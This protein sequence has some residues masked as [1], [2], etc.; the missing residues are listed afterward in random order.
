MLPLRT[1]LY[2]TDFSD[3]SRYAFRL[4]SSL[5][6]DHGACLVVLHVDQTLGPMVAYGE[7]LAQLQPA[8]SQEK[9]WHALRHFQVADP[10]VRVEHRLVEGDAANEILRV[11]SQIDCDLIVMGTHGR[12][13]LGRLLMGSVAEQVVRKARCPVA[14]VK[15]PRPSP[16]PCASSTPTGTASA[17]VGI[18]P[19]T[20]TS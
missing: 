11:A 13:G 3:C 7:A 16:A 17:S 9:L 19:S 10:N 8:D 20:S 5:A 4:A 18:C 6:R 15:A 1:I 2:T 14:T 12:T